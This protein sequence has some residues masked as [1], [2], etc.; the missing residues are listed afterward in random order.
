MKLKSKDALSFRL[1]KEGLESWDALTTAIKNLPYGRNT[2]RTDVS[3]VFKEQKG[4]CSSKHAFLKH[5]ADLNGFTNIKLLLGIY[6]M[7]HKNT[8]NIGN[9][10]LENN[11]DFLPEAHCY[12]SVDGERLDYTSRHSDFNRIKNEILLE[13]EIA[14]FQVS[15]FKVDFHKEFIRNWIVTDAIQFSFDVIWALREQCIANLTV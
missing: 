13:Q 8:P 2:N 11:I 6:K 9:V 15:E 5:V 12:L 1:K 14:P 10:L 7:H 3:L 4:T